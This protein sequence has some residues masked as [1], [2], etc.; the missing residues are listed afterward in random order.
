MLARLLPKF[1]VDVPERVGRGGII[2]VE[3]WIGSGMGDE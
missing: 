2:G 1:A 3:V